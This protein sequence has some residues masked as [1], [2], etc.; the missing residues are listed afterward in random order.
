MGEAI[1]EGD[2][3]SHAT[4]DSH[5]WNGRVLR[6]QTEP[7]TEQVALVEVDGPQWARWRLVPLRTLKG[8]PPPCKSAYSFTGNTGDPDH[9]ISPRIVI[10]RCDLVE[11]SPST[12]HHARVGPLGD[13]AEVFWP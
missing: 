2:R 8:E 4:R 11:H 10:V 13:T 12:Q 6:I 9:S 7:G 5:S 3:V 1:K